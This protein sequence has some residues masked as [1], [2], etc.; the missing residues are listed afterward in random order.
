MIIY[1]YQLR[2]YLFGQVS[3]VELSTCSASCLDFSQET[4]IC[5]PTVGLWPSQL[6]HLQQWHLRLIKVVA[7]C[8]LIPAVSCNCGANT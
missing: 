5:A 2:H 3:K 7:M 4:W 6:S 1:V 8:F